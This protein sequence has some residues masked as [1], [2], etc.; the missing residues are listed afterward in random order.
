M[1]TN[2]YTSY[3]RAYLTEV[4]DVRKDDDDFIESRA[5]DASEEYEVQLRA[6]APPACAQELAMEI[7]MEGLG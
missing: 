4:G 6:G 1:D 2:Y 3:L 7:L 5:D